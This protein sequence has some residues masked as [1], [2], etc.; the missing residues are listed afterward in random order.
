MPPFT[1]FEIALLNHIRC[2]PSMM[3]PNCWILVG[4]FEALCNF[5]KVKATVEA[6]FY[7]FQVNSPN[8][9]SWFYL[10]ARG[11]GSGVKKLFRDLKDPPRLEK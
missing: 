9:G 10:Q 1:D 11:H 4:S 7:Y 3:M 6:F 5:Y 2:A 8:K